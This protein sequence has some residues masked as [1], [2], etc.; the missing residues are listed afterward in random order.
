[1]V[2]VRPEWADFL[3]EAPAATSVSPGTD[4]AH[5]LSL[6]SAVVGPAKTTRRT[7]PEPK[8]LGMCEECFN[9]L[10]PDGTCPMECGE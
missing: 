2:K 1:M 3:T 4:G 9:V 5:R 6:S 8:P 7:A 10:N